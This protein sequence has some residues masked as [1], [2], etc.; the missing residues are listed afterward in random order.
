MERRIPNAP[1]G[2]PCH[3]VWAVEGILQSGLISGSLLSGIIDVDWLPPFF[4]GSTGRVGRL[5]FSSSRDPWALLA[6][7]RGGPPLLTSF[8]TLTVECLRNA[9]VARKRSP[10]INRL[11]NTQSSRLGFRPPPLGALLSGC[12]V[13]ASLHFFFSLQLAFV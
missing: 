2:R 5:H 4:L 9:S 10:A 6:L 1:E 11:C 7:A 12:H 8:A 13:T 3:V